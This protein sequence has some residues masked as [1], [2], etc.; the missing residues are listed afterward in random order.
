[1]Y[2]AVFHAHQKIDRVASRLFNE[3]VGND[4]AF[5]SA[6]LILHFE[7]KRGPDATRLKSTDGVEQPWHFIDPFDEDDV[8]LGETVMEHHRQLV[9]ALKTGN[10]ERAAFEAAWLA[11]ALVDGLTPAHHY[12]YERELEMLHGEKRENL[13][14]VRYKF[15]ATGDSKRDTIRRSLRIIGPRGL[16]TTH[17][18]FEAGAYMIMRPMRLNNALPS[19]Y[20]IEQL[21]SVGLRKYFHMQAREVGA[22]GMF[23]MF[24]TV[25]WTPK[26]ARTV[27]RE[28]VPRMVKVVVLAW[29]AAALDSGIIDQ[30]EAK[31]ANHRR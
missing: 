3:L 16:L 8:S 20:D 2:A 12:P 6:D 23:D 26:L 14:K 30:P 11:H 5:P 22:L 7:G 18:M 4:V 1:M 31:N 27:R 10:R 24:C 17:T 28:L 21:M 29:Y 25:G 13:K 19:N 15:M 9:L